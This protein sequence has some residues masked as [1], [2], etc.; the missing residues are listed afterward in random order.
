MDNVSG[1]RDCL[2]KRAI[3]NHNMRGYVTGKFMSSL[4]SFHLSIIMFCLVSGEATLSVAGL[5]N[6][7]NAL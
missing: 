4:H 2:Y 6:D 3:C 7:L 1:Q 5:S